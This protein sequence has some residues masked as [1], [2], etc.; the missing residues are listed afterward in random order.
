MRGV[1][2]DK[3]VER[4]RSQRDT[5]FTLGS[6]MLFAIFL[7]L[8][9]ICGLCF[10]AGYSLGHHSPG[11]T[12]T[13]QPQPAP[14][15][16]PLQGNGGIPKP[17]AVAQAPEAPVQ[18]PATDQTA[19][20]TEPAPGAPAPAQPA[21]PPAETAQPQVRPALGPA[22]APQATSAVAAQ[23]AIH[24]AMAQQLMVQV[25][26]VSNPEDA[27]VLVGALR[28]RGY[29]V[30]PRREPA[31]NFIHVRVGPFATRQIAD[32]WRNKLLSDGYNAV[33]QQ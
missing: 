4:A 5:E 17:S 18:P 19:T 15:Q 2:D 10:G 8:V 12:A 20:A 9:L 6:G 11:P 27:D 13:A 21:E 24:P 16:E 14:E 33:V 26:A 23:Q 25:A 28:K 30:V 22:E 3:E 1:F 29:P 31:D 7:G 32:Q